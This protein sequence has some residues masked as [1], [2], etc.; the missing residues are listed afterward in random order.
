M[1]SVTTQSAHRLSVHRVAKI[2]L[3]GHARLQ[4]T[5]RPKVNGQ[6][7]KPRQIARRVQDAVRGWS[8]KEIY[9]LL[10]GT[11]QPAPQD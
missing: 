7:G 2:G 3:L 11:E 6:G 5:D 8:G 9:A 4:Q 10:T 1:D